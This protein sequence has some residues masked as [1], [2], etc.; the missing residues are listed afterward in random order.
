M[1]GIENQIAI[2]CNQ[3]ETTICFGCDE[4]ISEDDEATEIRTRDCGYQFVCDECIE[5]FTDELRL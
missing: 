1:C 5:G 4:I 3:D 2:H